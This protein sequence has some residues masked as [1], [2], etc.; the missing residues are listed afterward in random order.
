[1]IDDVEKALT[2]VLLE[3]DLLAELVGD[4]VFPQVLPQ[5]CDYPA[6]AYTVVD[7]VPI[8]TLDGNAGL[9]S[10]R[11][12][13]DV[14]ASSYSDKAAV[15]REIRRALLAYETGGTVAGF[16]IGAVLLET[17]RDEPYEH[18]TKSFRTILDFMIWHN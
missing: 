12:Q 16:N 8:N 3:S 7:A 10:V 9:E 11:V 18:E 13:F 17:Q 2:Q 14:W 6:I 5:F 4:R 1:M 15:S